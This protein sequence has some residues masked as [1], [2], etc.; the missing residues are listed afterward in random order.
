M[1]EV[2]TDHDLMVAAYQE[3]RQRRGEP[4]VEV[5]EF[6]H[7]DA[8]DDYQETDDENEVQR[9]VCLPLATFKAVLSDNPL[10]H[11]PAAMLITRAWKKGPA[12]S[13]YYVQVKD[14]SGSRTWY[15]RGATVQDVV[16]F[17]QSL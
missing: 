15:Y 11:T 17:Y 2:V 3:A 7:F 9:F 6:R 4:K 10:V 12:Q 14:E 5:V 8:S 13:G 16:E 1:P